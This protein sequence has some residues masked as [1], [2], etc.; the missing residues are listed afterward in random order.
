MRMLSAVTIGSSARIRP[1]TPC[2]EAEYCGACV[3]PIQDAASMRSA[4]SVYEY[5]NECYVPIEPMR[6]IAFHESGARLRLT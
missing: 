5:G 6:T 4:E 1:S 3:T 2:F